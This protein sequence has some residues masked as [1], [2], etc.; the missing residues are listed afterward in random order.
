MLLFVYVFCK[1]G[2]LKLRYFLLYCGTTF[3]AISNYRN[4]LL[5]IIASFFPL[6]SYLKDSF[7]RCKNEKI[8]SRKAKC[9]Q[10]AIYCLVTVI[11]TIVVYMPD[12]TK[13]FNDYTPDVY[14][15]V[16]FIVDNY[17]MQGALNALNI[18]C[19]ISVNYKSETVNIS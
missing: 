8:L 16:E 2:T 14:D 15:S 5:F 17:I 13:F 12:F 1:K 3:L 11:S 18:N 6:A 7:S 19:V 4:I 10:I 9:F